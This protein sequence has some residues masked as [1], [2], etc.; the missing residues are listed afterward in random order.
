MS[1][2]NSLGD[3][4]SQKPDDA[5][6]RDDAEDRDDAPS[7]SPSV[8][9]LVKQYD[10]DVSTIPGSGPAGRIRV[11]DV[12]AMLGGSATTPT[13]GATD[14]GGAAAYTSESEPEDSLDAS[15]SSVQTVRFFARHHPATTLFECDLTNVLA[16][17]NRMRESGLRPTPTAY[18]AFALLRALTESG[19]DRE[20]QGRGDLGVVIPRS[21]GGTA[22]AL[23]EKPLELSFEALNAQLLDPQTDEMAEEA[24]WLIHHHGLGGSIA[25]MPTPLGERQQLSLGIGK[26]R[27]VV[28]IKSVSGVESPRAATQCYLSLSFHPDEFELH[29]ANRLLARCVELLETWPTD[30]PPA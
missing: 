22:T 9:R 16:H 5:Q 7:L 6:D 2:F 27:R 29:R 30:G 21:D 1:D 23:L 8:R 15:L 20:T 28:A 19:D 14:E 10:L 4:A 18:Y 17:Q 11:A 24:T 13:R 25:A 3:D 26:P 12:M